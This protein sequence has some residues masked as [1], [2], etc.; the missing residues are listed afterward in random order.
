MRTAHGEGEGYAPPLIG[1]IPTGTAGPGLDGMG[2]NGLG[3]AGLGLAGCVAVLAGC[4]STPPGFASPDPNKR[5][6][7][8]V[9]SSDPGVPL[10]GERTLAL[11]DQ[12]ESLDPAARMLAIAA[13]RERTGETFGYSHAGPE[14]QRRVAVSRWRDWA[15]EQARDHEPEGPGPQR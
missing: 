4:F 3:L 12:L 15:A 9:A 8:I 2:L 1:S 13:L 11:I 7:A 10:D 5:I 14:A 6:Q